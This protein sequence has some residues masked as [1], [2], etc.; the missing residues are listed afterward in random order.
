MTT[1]FLIRGNQ[2]IATVDIDGDVLGLPLFGGG[3]AMSLMSSVHVQALMT[4]QGWTLAQALTAL[5]LADLRASM[6][7]T[8]C[9]NG[10][11]VSLDVTGVVAYHI[12]DVGN[13]SLWQCDGQQ[14]DLLAFHALAWEMQPTETLGLTAVVKTFDVD[15]YQAAVRTATGM[16]IAEALV[17]RD[18]IATYLEGLGYNNTTALRASTNE[19][20]QMLGIATALGYTEAQL[21]NAMYE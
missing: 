3:D 19:H 10:N 1:H 5:G 11:P 18:K 4:S 16:S 8:I 17:R 6:L 20:A 9:L 7:K 14:D 21:W 15:F 13:Y 12:K 2:V